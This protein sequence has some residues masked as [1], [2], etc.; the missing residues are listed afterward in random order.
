MSGVL[1][2]SLCLEASRWRPQGSSAGTGAHS[3]HSADREASVLE[4]QLACSS[5]PVCWPAGAAAAS[6]AGKWPEEGAPGMVL[7]LGAPSPAVWPGGH[8][9]A[10]SLLCERHRAGPGRKHM[11]LHLPEDTGSEYHGEAEARWKD[12]ALGSVPD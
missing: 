3:S 11:E 8:S 9:G 2:P 1:L 10:A 6:G 4:R 7:G 5:L 12:G